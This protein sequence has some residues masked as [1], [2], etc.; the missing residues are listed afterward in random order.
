[1]RNPFFLTVIQIAIPAPPTAASCG[2]GTLG[3]IRSRNHGLQITRIKTATGLVIRIAIRISMGNAI[4]PRRGTSDMVQTDPVAALHG[5]ETTMMSA[6]APTSADARVG[7]TAA[8][9]TAKQSN[10]VGPAPARHVA[11]GGRTLLK[12]DL[13]CLHPCRIR[14]L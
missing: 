7:M 6:V 13:C 4:S 3:I 5:T 2:G 9:T 8:P 11:E 14:H 1:M 12:I 10:G